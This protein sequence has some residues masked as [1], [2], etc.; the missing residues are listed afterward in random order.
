[1]IDQ[2]QLQRQLDS[3]LVPAPGHRE[4][5]LAEL[6]ERAGGAGLLEAA[7]DALDSPLGRLL[8]ATTPIGVVRVGFENEAE[9]GFLSDL[10]TRVSARVLRAPRRLD[11]A[12]RQLDEY[13]GGHRRTFELDLDWRLTLGFRRRVLRATAAIPF[14]ETRSYRDVATTA[15]SPNAVRAAGSAL[16]TNPLPII[17]PCHRVLR[18]DGALGGFRGG[19]EMKRA[20][21]GYEGARLPAG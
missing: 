19:I 3:E 2:T 1:M 6:S 7:Y 12:R 18:T 20:L 10:A 17:V 11:D 16:A 9:E 21:L 14:G 8:V 15:G 13:F 5:L 4:R